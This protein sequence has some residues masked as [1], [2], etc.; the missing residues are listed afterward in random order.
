MK[1]GLLLE[2]GEL[3][4]FKHGQ[5]YHA[6]V[7]EHDGSIYYINARGRAVK[8][9]HIVHGTMTNGLLKRG[10]YYFDQDCRLVANS[11]I[12][13]KKR[14]KHLKIKRKHIVAASCILGVLLF[15]MTI[16]AYGNMDSK[17]GTGSDSSF[18]SEEDYRMMLPTF[19]EDVLLCSEAAKQLYDGYMSAELAVKYGEP[20]RNFSF[21]YDIRETSGTFLLSERDDF[22]NAKEYTLDVNK[23]NLVIDNLKTG[24]TYYYKIT[25]AGTEYLGT[26][27]TAL[28]TR[29]VYLPGVVNTRDIGGYTTMDGKTVK[30]GL[31]IRGSEIDGLVEKHYFIHSEAIEAVQDTFGFVYDFD[32]RG[33]GIYIGEYKSRLGNN[34]S[35]KFF[36]APQY[37][38][39]FNTEYQVSLREIFSELAKPENYPMY[40][41]C[42]HGADRTGTIIFL[43]QGILNLSEEEMIREYQRTGFVTG[44]YATSNNM[45][46]IIEGLKHFDGDTLQEKIVTYLTTVIG[47]TE[48]EI[49]T[50]RNI[51]LEE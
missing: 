19:N 7:I 26:F 29:Y 25:V 28:S 30:Q 20:Y 47:V 36:G 45:Q 1:E 51:F 33:G 38:Q 35:H 4:Y 11:Y 14:K 24:T 46:I 21:T 16:V 40:L 10:T 6:G 44:T 32:L 3:I 18:S 17:H 23:N 42:T 5:P 41:H 39:I 8:G 49:A 22:I 15:L 2:N 43:L 12:A 34:V 31:L 37:G 27:T 48:E 13:P 9:E 50:I